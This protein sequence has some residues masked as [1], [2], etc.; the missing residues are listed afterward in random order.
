M[1]PLAASPYGDDGDPRQSRTGLSLARKLTYGFLLVAA[2]G[3]VSEVAVRADDYFRKG[4]PLGAAPSYDDLVLHDGLGP[5]GRP[6]GRYAEFRLNSLGFRSSEAALVTRPGCWRVMAIG[7]SETFGT[8][9][10][11]GQEYPAQLQ[12]SLSIQGCYQVLNAALVGM[13]LR[14]MIQYWTTWASRAH[15][16]LVV[17][18]AIPTLYLGVAAPVFPA[19]AKQPKLAPARTSFRLS[20]R[21]FERLH[22]YIHYP[23]FIQRQRVQNALDVL[24]AGRPPD[25]YFQSV[26]GDRLAQYRRDLDSLVVAIRATGSEPILATYPIIFASALLPEDS[27][28]MA[29]WRQYSPRAQPAVMLSFTSAANEAVRE[30]GHERGVRVV[31]LAARMNGRQALFADITHYNNEGAHIVAGLVARTILDASVQYVGHQAD[32]RQ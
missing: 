13:G 7:S 32:R 24:T 10:T 3:A 30:L 16:D 22:D 8:G 29:A 27:S 9:T 14:A 5:H 2:G 21:L 11:L 20:S 19:H 4:I 18:L 6:N 17:V 1:T 31:D 25:W 23:D 12:D 28:L 15:P 26:P